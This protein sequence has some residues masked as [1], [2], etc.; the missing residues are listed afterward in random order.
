MFEDL[1]L[2][3]LIERICHL[4]PDRSIHKAIIE[5]DIAP[6]FVIAIEPEM[7]QTVEINPAV[8]Y[9]HVDGSADKYDFARLGDYDTAGTNSFFLAMEMNK[10]K[11]SYLEA[12]RRVEE[13]TSLDRRNV[14]LYGRIVLNLRTGF[15][16]SYHYLVGVA[17]PKNLLN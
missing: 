9:R 16:M 1:A 13:I 7:I 3:K 17:L 12:R 4:V 15:P 10:Q 2:Q 11:I 6:H 5:S 8:L 14:K